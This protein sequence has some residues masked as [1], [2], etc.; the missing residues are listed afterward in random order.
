MISA[1]I[2]NLE[3]ADC[4]LFIHAPEGTCQQLAEALGEAGKTLAGLTETEDSQLAIEQLVVQ[5]AV[6]PGHTLAA[7][8]ESASRLIGEPIYLLID[9]AERLFL[10]SEGNVCSSAFHQSIWPGELGAR[11]RS[12]V[13]LNSMSIRSSC[14]VKR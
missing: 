10:R 4:G 12:K 14:T 9:R 2:Q 7:T 1:L 8:L 3:Q 6:D 5:L 13:T 11:L